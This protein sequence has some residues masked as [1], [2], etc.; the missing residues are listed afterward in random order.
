MSKRSAPAFSLDDS[1]DNIAYARRHVAAGRVPQGI[2][3]E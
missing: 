1:Q 2:S 3:N